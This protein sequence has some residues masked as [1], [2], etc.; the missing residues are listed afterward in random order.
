MSN[1]FILVE[2]CVELQDGGFSCSFLGLSSVSQLCRAS[3]CTIR[4]MNFQKCVTG[5]CQLRADRGYSTYESKSAV[6]LSTHL[7]TTYWDHVLF[8]VVKGCQRL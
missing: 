7:H 1:R 6:L 3:C 8:T 4:L 2:I 5:L